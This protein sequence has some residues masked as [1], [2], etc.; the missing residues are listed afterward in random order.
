MYFYKIVW[1][2]NN[3]LVSNYQPCIDYFIS[4]NLLQKCIYY[5]N[6]GTFDQQKEVIKIIHSISIIN[7]NKYLIEIYNLKIPELLLV[8]LKAMI[9]VSV[10]SDLLQIFDLLLSGINEAIKYYET[11]NIIEILENIQYSHDVPSSMC[12]YAENMVN[13][14]YGKVYQSL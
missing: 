11:L 7:D 2:I 6:S 4:N 10:M 8:I 1:V 13:R 14:Y 9:D 12:S 5:L 3:M